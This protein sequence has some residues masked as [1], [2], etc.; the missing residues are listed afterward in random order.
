MVLRE[1]KTSLGAGDRKQW[2]VIKCT[3]NLS[4]EEVGM[5][6][7]EGDQAWVT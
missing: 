5:L 6:A 2:S 4:S 3:S 1:L 7:G